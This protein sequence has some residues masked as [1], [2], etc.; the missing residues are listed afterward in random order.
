M[1]ELMASVFLKS[2]LETL[3]LSFLQNSCF[4]LQCLVIFFDLFVSRIRK[5]W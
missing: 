4:L 1:L 5:K 2:L 3:K